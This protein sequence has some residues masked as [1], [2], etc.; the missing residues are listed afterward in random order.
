[1]QLP[2]LTAHESRT[3]NSQ[4]GIQD[5]NGDGSRG[6]LS[7][8][9]ISQTSQNESRGAID[10]DGKLSMRAFDLALISFQDSF[11]NPRYDR[12]MSSFHETISDFY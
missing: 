11:Y 3:S 2:D 8:Q 6:V 5:G 12:V 9:L 1:M 4:D 7:D 10:V